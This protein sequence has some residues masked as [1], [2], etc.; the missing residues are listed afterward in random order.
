MFALPSPRHMPCDRCGASV[1]RARAAE[2]LCDEERRLDYE[3]FHLR[4]ELERFEDGLG[5]WLD[6]PAGRFERFYAERGR[7]SSYRSLKDR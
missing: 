1:D 5:A 6:T 7:H 4:D 3:L 2:H